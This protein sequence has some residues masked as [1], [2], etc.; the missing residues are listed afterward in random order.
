MGER[1]DTLMDEQ[2]SYVDDSN[3]KQRTF[4]LDLKTMLWFMTKFDH[5]LRLDVINFAFEKLEK[6]KTLAV[7]EAKKPK[8]YSDGRMSVRRCLSEAWSDEEDAPQEKELWEALIW[9][10]FAESVAKVTTTKKIPNGLDGYIGSTKGEHRG[11][12]TYNP[13]VVKEAWDEFVESGKPVKSERDKLIEEFAQVSK[14]YEDKL[15]ELE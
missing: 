14:Y 15:K 8:I 3:R 11:F 12:A 5:A 7:I 4:N 6:E 2:T 9:K 10:G 1:L 13:D